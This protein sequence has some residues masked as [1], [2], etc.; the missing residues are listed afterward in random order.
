MQNMLPGEVKDL[1]GS[2]RI[3]CHSPTSPTPCWHPLHCLLYR[4]AF[5]KHLLAAFPRW[6]MDLVVAS[7][8]ALSPDSGG[9]TDGRNKPPCPHHHSPCRLRWAVLDRGR[10]SSRDQ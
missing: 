1:S 2:G 3:L 6:A 4:K 5:G 10:P 8:V 9:G 7:D